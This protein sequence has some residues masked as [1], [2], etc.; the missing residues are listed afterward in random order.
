M[1]ASPGLRDGQQTVVGAEDPEAYADRIAGVVKEDGTRQPCVRGLRVQ[2]TKVVANRSAI[3]TPLSERLGHDLGRVVSECGMRVGSRIE[4]LLEC[5]YELARG[6]RRIFR[7][8]GHP[9]VSAFRNRGVGQDSLPS[10]AT[11][12]DRFEPLAFGFRKD[13]KSRRAASRHE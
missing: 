6:R 8:K 10:V 5:G 13:L 12:K 9:D 1:E 3:G 11:D 4:F 7:G 2:R